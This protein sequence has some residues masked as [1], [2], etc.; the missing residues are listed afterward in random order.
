VDCHPHAARGEL[1]PDA[2]QRS[3]HSRSRAGGPHRRPNESIGTREGRVA[4]T[5]GPGR[6]GDPRHFQQA[7]VRHMPDSVLRTLGNI[8]LCWSPCIT[9]RTEEAPVMAV[10]GPS[11]W[12]VQGPR[13]DAIH[14]TAIKYPAGWRR[15]ALYR[16]AA[17][18]GLRSHRDGCFGARA[19]G[20]RHRSRVFAHAGRPDT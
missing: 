6:R 3:D 8:R 2:R 12:S 19:C 13:V 20:Y 4:T 9:A 14:V 17:W 1:R 7:A 18:T 15:N 16:A 11:L 5:S 10:S